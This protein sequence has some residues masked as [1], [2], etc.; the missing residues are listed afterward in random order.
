MATTTMQS[1]A[2]TQGAAATTAAGGQ[3]SDIAVCVC[4]RLH[5]CSC[6]HSYYHH[7]QDLCERRVRGIPRLKARPRRRV[8][9]QRCFQGRPLELP[10]ELCA[11][12]R[13]CD[14]SCAL[15]LSAKYR[16][17]SHAAPF[18]VHPRGG[19]VLVRPTNRVQEC[20]PRRGLTTHVSAL[21][22]STFQVPVSR[23]QSSFPL[24]RECN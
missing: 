16:C 4:A 19:R 10:V 2:I 23:S 13:R 20:P 17:S 6:E 24:D 3:S 18:A 9:S 22:L 14:R 15:S 11:D 5:P 21:H 1:A 8:P 12:E 7:H